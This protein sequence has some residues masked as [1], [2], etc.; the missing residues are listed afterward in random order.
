MPIAP[1]TAMSQTEFTRV[2]TSSA[3]EA[4]ASAAVS[5]STIAARPSCQATAAMSP[6]A[7]TFTPS[8]KA[9]ARREPRSRGSHGRLTATSTN[10]GRKMATVASTAPGRPASTKPMKVAV[11]NTGPGV[12]CPTAIA[13]SSCRSVSQPRRSTKSARRNASSM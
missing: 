9:A 8:R 13:S 2:P 3:A 1:P 11:V 5:G 10:E 4:S 6:S 7:A 12:T